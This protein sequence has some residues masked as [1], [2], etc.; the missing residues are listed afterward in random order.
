[1]NG[2]CGL[3]AAIEPFAALYS[4]EPSAAPRMV[5][6]GVTGLLPI[7]SVRWKVSPLT[8]RFQSTEPVEVVELPPDATLISEVLLRL[9][10]CP[11]VALPLEPVMVK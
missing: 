5:A 11:P 7:R 10:I 8:I 3:L 6:V 4:P 9:P 1:M 2:L